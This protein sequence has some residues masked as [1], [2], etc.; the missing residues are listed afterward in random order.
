M[1]KD[2][3]SRRE[4]LGVGAAVAGASLL[5]GPIFPTAAASQQAS[6]QASRGAASNR[7]RFG[8]VG[9]GERDAGGH[10]LDVLARVVVVPLDELDAERAGERG[11]D[12]ALAGPGDAHDDVK[13]LHGGR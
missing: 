4:F 7:V 10:A 11:A 6:S 13:A 9:V 2:R 5:G 8:I 3:F 1:S 12:G